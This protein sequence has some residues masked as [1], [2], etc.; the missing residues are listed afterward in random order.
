MTGHLLTQGCPVC[1]GVQMCKRIKLIANPIS[2]GDS[3]PRI[4][5]AVCFLTEA[6]AHVDLFLTGKRGDA[7]DMAL[8]LNPVDYDL[9]IA[10][11][12]DGTLNEVAN[13]LLGRGL[14]LAFLPLGTAN[15]MALEMGIPLS[16]EGAC[17]VAL[18]GE[19]RPIA[20]A[21]VGDDVFLMMAGIGYDA[22]AVRAVSGRLKR[23]TGKF[24]YLV[25]GLSSFICYR[26]LAMTLC[27]ADGDRR[28]VWH[29]IVS[30][31]RLYGGRY[32]MAPGAGLTK[33]TLT[34]CIVDRSG[35]LPLALFWLRIFLGGRI[36][37]SVQRIESTSF[38]LDGG[39]APVQIDGDDFGHL[40]LTINCRTDQLTMMFPTQ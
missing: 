16:I 39:D 19:K 12:G 18:D 34:A 25:A 9:V 15:V 37:G 1:F 28:T 35:R 24:A 22:A 5:T 40:P 27:S 13:G 3:R 33:P 17:R 4:D 10:A 21:S 11:G 30:N 23:I 2:G 7:R 36:F 32:V 29:A 8:K 20:L 26:P 38:N 6:G 14:S 31:I